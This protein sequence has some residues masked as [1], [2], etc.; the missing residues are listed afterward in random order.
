VQSKE[1]VAPEEQKPST[2]SDEPMKPVKICANCGSELAD[3]V[4]FCSQCGQKD[5]D[6][7]VPLKHLIEE[8]IEGFLHFDSKSLNTLYKLV[9]KPG[10]LTA[11]FIKGRRVSYV[12]PVRLYVFISFVFFLLL[13]WSSGKHDEQGT[14]KPGGMA[15]TFYGIRSDSLGGYDEERLDSLMRARSVEPTALNGYVL[16]QMMRIGNSGAQEFSHLLVKS[17]SY[18]MFVL[19]PAFAFF[20]FIL[21]RK[22]A[23][24]YIG[25]L[26]FSIH[27]HAFAFLGLIF[28]MLA[29]RLSGLSALW[30][31]P[32][33]VMPFYLYLAQRRVYA[34][35]RFKT[36]IKN[37]ALNILQILA[38]AG[39]FLFTVFFSLLLF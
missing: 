7:N 8:I 19:M 4:H 27:I 21:H 25:T 24:Y 30:F 39:L 23:V 32:L 36:L 10:F 35:S 16:K 17:V 34:D 1:I 33:I 31:L 18:M 37:V 13:A 9:F 29:S 3:G 15:I 5:H 26:I 38:L 22:K 14:R 20:V 28:I 2:S 11:E 6:L 12:A